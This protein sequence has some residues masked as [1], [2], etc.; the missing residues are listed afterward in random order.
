MISNWKTPFVSIVFEKIYQRFE[1][2]C[3]YSYFNVLFLE[4]I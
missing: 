3:I 4:S 1:G 2:L